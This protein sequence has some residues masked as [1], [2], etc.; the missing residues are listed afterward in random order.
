M[1]PVLL[2]TRKFQRAAW[3]PGKRL[4]LHCNKY[5]LAYDPNDEANFAMR[6]RVHDRVR[7]GEMPPKQMAR[8]K[9]SELEAFIRG[10][11]ATLEHSERAIIDR[12]GRAVR[13]ST[14]A[15]RRDS[16]VRG[17]MDGSG[18]AAGR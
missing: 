17:A 15:I 8:P 11:A 6:V 2:F 13:Q 4:K 14:R 16:R 1:S 10:L 3:D 18:G 9:P 12:N 7:E 5:G